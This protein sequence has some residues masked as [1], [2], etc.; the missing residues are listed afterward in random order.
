MSV[1]NMG[2]ILENMA[3]IASNKGVGE[4]AC[5]IGVV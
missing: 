4:K 2:I 1:E 3:V 5:F